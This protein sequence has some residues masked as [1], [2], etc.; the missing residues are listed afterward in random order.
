MLE[1]E[2]MR[3]SLKVCKILLKI[4]TGKILKIK[5]LHKIYSGSIATTGCGPP[6]AGVNDSGWSSCSMGVCNIE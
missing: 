3:F 1:A 5:I 6:S 2:T 4:L